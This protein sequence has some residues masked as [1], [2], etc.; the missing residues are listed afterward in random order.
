MNFSPITTRVDYKNIYNGNLAAY[1][2]EVNEP[3]FDKIQE[4]PKDNFNGS[5]RLPRIQKSD[6]LRHRND[7]VRNK[8]SATETILKGDFYKVCEGDENVDQVGKIFFSEENLKRV[9]KLIK[10]EVFNRTKGEFKLDTDQ[11]ESDLLVAMRA[12]YY[13]HARFLDFKVVRQVK[14]LNQ[15][16]IEYIIQDIITGIKQSYAYIQEINQPIKPINRP[17][18]VSNAGRRTLPALTSVWGF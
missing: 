12:V 3:T 9:Q 14:E 2:A 11:D 1:N 16:V 13:E 10:R 18:N 5:G 6:K 4:L 17:L 15:K 7:R 8:N